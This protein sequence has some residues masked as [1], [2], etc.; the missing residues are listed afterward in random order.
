MQRGYRLEAVNEGYGNMQ[1]VT[2]HKKTG[3]VEAVS[4]P[5]GEGSGIIK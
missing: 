1:A 5:R 4:D 2:W 3:H